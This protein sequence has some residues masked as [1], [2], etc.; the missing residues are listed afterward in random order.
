METFFTWPIIY[1]VDLMT[2]S[3]IT[4]TARPWGEKEYLYIELWLDV[5]EK[6]RWAG[7]QTVQ[8][9]EE[10]ETFTT[11]GLI[12][13]TNRANPNG[14]LETGEAS[15][16]FCGKYHTF[17]NARICAK[18]Y[19]IYNRSVDRTLTLV[20]EMCSIIYLHV[21]N[22][23]HIWAHMYTAYFFRWCYFQKNQVNG[24]NKE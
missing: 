18:G 3:T 23:S 2:F 10:F 22:I 6:K 8:N 16:M 7:S 11:C 4:L 19:V 13:R 17:F 1:S 12:T 5:E 9:R 20:L 15:K 14:Y 24:C 21:S